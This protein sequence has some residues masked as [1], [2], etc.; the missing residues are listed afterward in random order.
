M[1]CVFLSLNGGVEEWC[2]HIPQHSTVSLGSLGSEGAVGQQELMTC[3]VMAGWLQ[4]PQKPP[5]K[6]W[7]ASKECPLI[8]KDKKA[9]KVLLDLQASRKDQRHG[10]VSVPPDLGWERG[11]HIKLP[12]VAFWDCGATG[13]R[14][15]SGWVLNVCDEDQGQEGY[16]FL[17]LIC[18]TDF[19][20]EGFCS[21]DF[22][23]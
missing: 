8:T 15:G 14:C 5:V 10:T 2:H 9:W 23:T 4:G 6:A 21:F 18:K 11:S 3:P 16:P 13:Q 19:S 20:R 22:S 1:H 7:G 12:G 17:A